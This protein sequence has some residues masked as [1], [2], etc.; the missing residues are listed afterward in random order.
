MRFALI[1]PVWNPRA[2]RTSAVLNLTFHWSTTF[3]AQ[4]DEQAWE[5]A[6]NFYLQL[7]ADRGWSRHSGPAATFT[8]GVGVITESR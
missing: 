2:R 3:G 6:H 8:A 5:C 4:P 1:K 7:F